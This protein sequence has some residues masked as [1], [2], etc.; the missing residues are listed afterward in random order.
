LIVDKFEFAYDNKN[1]LINAIINS[2]E[3]IFHDIY[4]Y[5][6]RDQKLINYIMKFLANHKEAYD[7]DMINL[8]E[9]KKQFILNIEKYEIKYKIKKIDI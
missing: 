5:Y 9:Y 6:Y 1:E 3:D 8:T 7:C 2:H 4:K